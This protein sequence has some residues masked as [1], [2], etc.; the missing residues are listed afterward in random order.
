M[1]LFYHSTKQ[2]KKQFI[3]VLVGFGKITNKY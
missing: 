2:N 3:Y 1:I